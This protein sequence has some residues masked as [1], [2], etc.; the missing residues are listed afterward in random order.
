M[1]FDA[2]D[3]LGKVLVLRLTRERRLGPAGRWITRA[4]SPSSATRG[5]EAFCDRVNTSTVTPMRPSSRAVSRT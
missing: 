1:R 2:L 3:E 4:P 5:I